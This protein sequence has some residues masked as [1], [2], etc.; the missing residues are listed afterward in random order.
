MNNEER[1]NYVADRYRS[2]GFKVILRPGPDDLPPFAKDFKVEVLATGADG[3][4]LASAKAS[5]LELEAD[6]NVPRYAEITE[7]QPGW[8]FDVLVLGPDGGLPKQHRQASE[9]SED[10]IRRTLDEVERMLQAGFVAS[11]FAAAWGA[12]EAAMRRRVRAGGGEAGWG[13]MPR[14]ML[15]DLYSSGEIST[16]VLRDLEG[17]FQVT[18]AIVHGFSAPAL[19]PGAVR[20]LVDTARRLLAESQPVKQTA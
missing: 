6:P 7:K 1:L 20:F 14:T 19:D 2:L 13:T 12:L 15:N 5:P 10:D 8:R 9:P 3:N 11:S 16:S 4:V 18:S 17:L